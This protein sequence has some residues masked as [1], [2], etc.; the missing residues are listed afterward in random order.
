M[1]ENIEL[2]ALIESVE[3]NRISAIKR[4]WMEAHAVQD[5]ISKYDNFCKGWDRLASELWPEDSSGYRF[6]KLTGLCANVAWSASVDALLLGV[7]S[8]IRNET[9]RLESHAQRDFERAQRDLRKHRDHRLP[10]RD[11]ME[12]IGL[13]LW[14]VRSNSMHGYKTPSGP[15]GPTNRDE[16]ICGLGATVIAEMYKFAFPAW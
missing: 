16:Q 1:S 5:S 10:D 14:T 9:E 2:T 6:K 7:D 11:L 3:L 15:I 13:L 12:S 4:L 8:P